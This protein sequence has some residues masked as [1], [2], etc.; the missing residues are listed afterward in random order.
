M[1]CDMWLVTHN[2][3][4]CLTKKPKKCQKR[5]KKWLKIDQKWRRVSKWQYFLVLV[6]LSTHA[7]RVCVSRMRYF[8]VSNSYHFFLKLFMVAITKR[9]IFF[10]IFFFF[11]Q[12]IP[13]LK[14]FL[15]VIGHT[16]KLQAGAI[17]VRWLY[18]QS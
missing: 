1:T 3:W 5:N 7:E 4:F 2:T 17:E 13:L 15:F 11:L 10:W 12:Q 9:T 14:T 18:C 8:L 16:V 6:L